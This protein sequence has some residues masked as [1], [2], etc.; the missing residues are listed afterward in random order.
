MIKR[1]YWLLVVGLLISSAEAQGRGYTARACGF[2]LDDDGVIGEATD[3]CTI[4]D[5]NTSTGVFTMDPDGDGVEEDINFVG[6]TGTDDVNCG[7]PDNACATVGYVLAGSNSSYAKKF[8]GPSDGAEDIMCVAGTFTGVTMTLAQSGLTATHTARNSHEYPSDPSMIIGWDQDGDG[9]YPPFDTDDTALFDGNLQSI[10]VFRPGTNNYI[11][12]AHL[13][14][15]DYIDKKFMDATTDMNHYYFHDL[16][17]VDFHKGRTLGSG[18]ILFSMFRPNMDWFAIENI[19]STNMGY[20]FWRGSSTGGNNWRFSEITA[21]WFSAS[22]GGAGA[23]KPWD[24]I[25]NI[26][27]ENSIFDAQTA[28]WRVSNFATGITIAQ[29]AQDVVIQNN[30]FIDWVY[31]VNIQPSASG[32]CTTREIKNVTVDSN[33]FS[34][35]FSGWNAS[36]IRLAGSGSASANYLGTGIKII[37]NFF[38]NTVSDPSAILDTNSR[39]GAANPGDITI[40]GNT[41]SGTYTNVFDIKPGSNP[42]N[43]YTISNNIFT[44]TLGKNLSFTN[45]P[46]S[47]T[48]DGNVYS[49]SADYKLGGNTKTSL[50]DWQTLTSQDA[51][52]TE[53]NPTL[54]NPGAG[55]LHLSQNDTCAI[56]AGINIISVT[57]LD[58]DSE[59]RSE[60]SP[61]SG[62]DEV[63]GGSIPPVPP[64]NVRLV[65]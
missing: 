1:L 6:S 26:V 5:G 3:D 63:Q 33:R 28:L 49:A 21:T 32:F 46:S 35:N 2:D 56:G 29:C 7:A 30:E 45:T 38:Y 42:I 25:G 48:M 10:N 64:Q 51:N 55:D 20:W 9:S 60:T 40:V 15:K 43:T 12:I 17:M 18:T 59:P 19:S 39:S 31:A 52:S 13:K 14:F 47:L 23:M 50:T 8:D 11:E 61:D 53:C 62:A 4:C 22:T 41:F 44:G 36:G 27:V 37:N 65:P 58:I 24:T 54:V 16:E 57:S 34:T